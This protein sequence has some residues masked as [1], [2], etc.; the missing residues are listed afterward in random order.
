MA[1]T[2]NTMN[3]SPLA[4]LPAVKFYNHRRAYVYGQ[5][6]PLVVPLNRVSCFVFS[7][8]EAD[9]G[10]HNW[11]LVNYNTGVETSIVSE[12]LA[13]GLDSYTVDGKTMTIYPGSVNLP[14]IDLTED[15]YYIRFEDDAGNF[16]F[17]EIFAWQQNIDN[18]LKYLKLEWWHFEDFTYPG[19]TIRYTFPFKLWAYIY[20]DIGKPERMKEETVEPRDGREFPLKQI[21][22]KVFKFEF[23]AP[24]YFVDAIDLV[25]QHDACEITHMGRVYEVEKF[26]MTTEWLDYGD[27]ARVGIEFRTDTVVVV[28]GRSYTDLD[29]EVEEGGCFTPNYEAIAWISNPSPEYT[30]K[31]WT[32]EFGANH[33]F[34]NGEYVIV[35]IFGFDILRQ[36]QASSGTLIPVTM[37]VLETVHTVHDSRN[38]FVRGSEYFFKSSGLHLQQNPIVTSETPVGNIY[39]LVGET[40]ENQLVEVWLRT[41]DGDVLAG[42]YFED[43]FTGAG[44][45][46][47]ASG[48]NAYF[49]RARTYICPN[50]GESDTVELEGIGFDEIEDTLIVYPDPGPPTPDSPDDEF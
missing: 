35:T 10:T 15:L 14:G 45:S 6:M 41:D 34:E 43:D 48:A 42:T 22:W 23:R 11:A 46:F 7:R 49:V 1:T 29:Y 39:T 24:E 8:D 36:F 17:T 19:G 32:D 5:I 9:T 47:D 20:T 28:N 4:F 33:S 38:P 26:V 25:W 44:I 27:F 16:I 21:S 37:N 13:T 31:Y 30:G 18:N 40:Y 50:I 12:L 2:L 3:V